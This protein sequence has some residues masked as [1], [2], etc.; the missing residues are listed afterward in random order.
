[1]HALLVA[2]ISYVPSA[3]PALRL[4]PL[5]HRR[6]AAVAA[7]ASLPPP[8]AASLPPTLLVADGD[9][10]VMDT[11]ADIAVYSILALVAGLTL[12]SIV[13]TLQKS[14]EEYGG[15]TPRD[16]EE[17]ANLQSDD[18]AGRLK[19]GAR[20][21]PVTDQ[22]TYPSP[23]EQ[24]AQAKVGRAPAAAAPPGTVEAAEQGA[25]RYDKRMLK[26]RKKQQKAKKS[27]R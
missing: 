21:D 16:D 14:N 24:K 27:K 10:S 17:V 12:Y 6:H 4:A 11:I 3:R 19:S 25:N 2:P 23:E 8:C 26:K 15:W 20:Y 7:D 18:G 22:W 13:V 9:F 1:M 5:H